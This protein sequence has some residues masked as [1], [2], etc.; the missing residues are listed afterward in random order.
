MEL[1]FLILTLACG[2]DKGGCPEGSG[3]CDTGD[4]GAAY[5]DLDGDGYSTA[6][7]DCDDTDLLKSPGL[8]EIPCDELNNDCDKQ[9]DD[10]PDMDG[11][12]YNICTDLSAYPN[13]GDCDDADPNRHP[14]MN[15]ICDGVDQNCDGIPDDGG[16][17]F[18]DAD[19]D[20]FGEAGSLPALVCDS[21]T[22]GYV[23]DDTDCDDTR[24]ATHPGAAEEESDVDCMKDGD[25]DGWG[26]D[27]PPLPG[28]IAGSDCD[29]GEDYIFPG[30]AEEES[31]V[32]CMSDEDGDGWG[33][34]SPSSGIIAGT[35]CDDL[36]PETYPEA[37]DAC[38]DG[39]DN[40]CDGGDDVDCD[41]P[42]ELMDSFSSEDD[43][44]V[45]TRY[46]SDN[47]N[48][49]VIVGRSDAFGN[50]Y[51]DSYYTTGSA[52]QFMMELKLGLFL[53]S[54]TTIAVGVWFLEMD[55]G[56]SDGTYYNIGH[57]TGNESGAY[58][59]DTHWDGGG[60]PAVATYDPATNQIDVIVY[61]AFDNYAPVGYLQGTLID[62]NTIELWVIS[63]TPFKDATKSHVESD[64]GSWSSLYGPFTWTDSG[65]RV[66]ALYLSDYWYDVGENYEGDSWGFDEGQEECPE[67]EVSH[68]TSSSQRAGRGKKPG[69]DITIQ[70]DVLISAMNTFGEMRTWPKWLALSWAEVVVWQI[71]DPYNREL[72]RVQLWQVIENYHKNPK[73]REDLDEMYDEITDPEGFGDDAYFRLVKALYFGGVDRELDDDHQLMGVT[74]GMRAYTRSIE[75]ELTGGPPQ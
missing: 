27:T 30:A 24:T 68:F 72:A 35:D 32:D 33:D 52:S 58:A 21:T 45:N 14:G 15:E 20:G 60:G 18:I 69:P 8:T 46:L 42:I 75:Q 54:N 12:G 56:V 11:D 36:D 37:Y 28:I 73:F 64:C 61:S 34:N 63:G 55:V 44:A 1:I 16:P 9:T 3:H 40:D 22:T 6:D 57:Y 59:P 29:D 49:S 71:E 26:D 5:I 31:D 10:S 25:K 51:D 19:G 4:S 39:M 70:P 17:W 53:E 2:N 66:S 65:S 13:G 67:T 38:W 47:G 48:C 7:G 23:A 74:P 43:T 50:Y 41:C 62:E